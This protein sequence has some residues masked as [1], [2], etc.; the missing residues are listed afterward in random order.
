MH[1][2]DIPHL[3]GCIVA[4]HFCSGF[5]L[6]LERNVIPNDSTH[7][8]YLEAKARTCHFLDGV[9]GSH[10]ADNMFLAGLGWADFE[11]DIVWNFTEPREGKSNCSRHCG[12]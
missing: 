10:F 4:I 8:A 3:I 7:S 11:A 1:P 6:G 2:L 9:N 5:W 12:S